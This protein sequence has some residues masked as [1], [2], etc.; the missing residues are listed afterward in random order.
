L[1]ALVNQGPK[2]K[3]AVDDGFAPLTAREYIQFRLEP[4][5]LELDYNIP[6]MQRELQVRETPCRPRSWANR[7]LV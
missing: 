4:A 2:S 3:G 7:S 6:R 5:L 1:K